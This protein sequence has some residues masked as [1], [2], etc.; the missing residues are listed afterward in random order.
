MRYRWWVSQVTTPKAADLD[1]SLLSGNAAPESSSA[2]MTTSSAALVAGVGGAT[3]TA[4]SAERLGMLRRPS[5]FILPR[6]TLTL[7][8]RLVVSI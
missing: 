5:S 1:T 2:E 8:A 4:Y 3:A 7:A 6:R